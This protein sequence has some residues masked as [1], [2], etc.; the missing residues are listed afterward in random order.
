[1][2]GFFE[3]YTIGDR[4][5]LGSHVFTADAI[6]AFA[7]KYDRQRFHM[8]EQGAADS[9]F[10]RLCASGWHTA[11]VWMRLMV[12]HRMAAAEHAARTGE[13][14][15]KLGPSPGFSDLVWKRPVY[16]GDEIHYASTLIDKRPLASRP[17]W[18]LLTHRNEGLNQDGDLVYAFTGSVFVERRG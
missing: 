4:I 1:M 18:G 11:A 8:S 12:D 13:A 15:G 10:G 16:A 2:T 3:D 6:V 17:E 5:E 7:S 14:V 9:H